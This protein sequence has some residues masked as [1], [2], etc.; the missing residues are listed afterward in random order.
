MSCP[1]SHVSLLLIPVPA[2]EPQASQGFYGEGKLA[3]SSFPHPRA[4]FSV[5]GRG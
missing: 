5:Q 2:P 3:P 4:P 1:Q